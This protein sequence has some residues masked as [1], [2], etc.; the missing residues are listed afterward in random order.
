VASVEYDGRSTDFAAA[1]AQVAAAAPQAVVVIGTGEAKAVVAALVKAHV[2][3][4]VAPLYLSDLALW[5]GVVQ[6]LTPAQT[7][8]VTGVRPGAAPSTDFLARLAAQAPDL[9]DVGYAAQT[10]DATVLVAL[11]AVA[12]HSTQ[13]KAIAAALPAL[14]TGESTCTVYAQCLALVRSGRSIAYVGQAGPVRLDSSGEPLDGTMG[15]YTFG[16]GG[17]YPPVGTYVTG[18]FPAAG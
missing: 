12:A 6:G 2:G 1:A 3:P 10:Y 17:T 5:P 13:G 8:G 7:V 9:V 15:V 18:T 14:T 16:A 11:A 4:D